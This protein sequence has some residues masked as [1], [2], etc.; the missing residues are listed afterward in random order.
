[1]RKN[2]FFIVILTIIVLGSSLIL[3]VYKMSCSPSHHKGI[4][5]ERNL[6]FENMEIWMNKTFFIL[7]CTIIL[8]IIILTIFYIKNKRK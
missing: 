3:F 2:I 4:I 1:M 6:I 7:L 5:M 8:S